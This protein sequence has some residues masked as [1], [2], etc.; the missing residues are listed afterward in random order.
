MSSIRKTLDEVS[1]LALEDEDG[2]ILK[3]SLESPLTIDQ[4][5]KYEASIAFDLPCE[6]RELLLVTNGMDYFGLDIMPIDEQ[7]CFPEQGI[8]A[9]HN[10]GNGDFDCIAAS[11]STYPDGAVVFMNHSPNVT[12][13][14]AGSLSE[15]LERAAGEIRETGILL[16]PSDYR[17]RREPGLYQHVLASLKGIPCELNR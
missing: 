17:A 2:A 14:I 12:V 8:I 11:P 6:L 3:V 16:H 4:L 10:W 1:S 9:F 7:S 5:A 13:R 15:W